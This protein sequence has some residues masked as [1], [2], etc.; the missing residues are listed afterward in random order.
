MPNLF[1]VNQIAKTYAQNIVRGLLMQ[2]V[3]CQHNKLKQFLLNTMRYD[4]L[5][6]Q[7]QIALKM[8]RFPNVFTF[9]EPGE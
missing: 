7:L 5:I 3:S 2:K 1:H 6:N 4:K 8:S 9:I